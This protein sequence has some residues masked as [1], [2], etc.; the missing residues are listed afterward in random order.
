[1]MLETGHV[2]ITTSFEARDSGACYLPSLGHER[3]MS[4]KPEVP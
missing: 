1:M 4:G 3:E 2:V